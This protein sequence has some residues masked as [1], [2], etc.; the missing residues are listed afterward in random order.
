MLEA[1]DIFLSV[2][3]DI[4]ASGTLSC[5]SCPQGTFSEFIGATAC[6]GCPLGFFSVSVAAS[7][8]SDCSPCWSKEAGPCGSVTK[9]SCH[10]KQC[11]RLRFRADTARGPGQY[12]CRFGDGP[13]FPEFTCAIPDPFFAQKSS[14]DYEDS[15]ACKLLP[16]NGKPR[17]DCHP[18]S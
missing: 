9:S 16:S 11:D 1:Q 15:L 2:L 7:S 17:L 8:F 10:V 6:K 18:R 5:P 12:L 4:L 3:P 13:T 14:C